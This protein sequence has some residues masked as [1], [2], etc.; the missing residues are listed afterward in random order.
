ML[1]ITWAPGTNP[2]MDQTFDRLREQQ[3]RD[4]KHRLWKNY[5]IKNFDFAVA[6]TIHFGDDGQP[7]LCSSIASRA[8]WPSGAYRI[9]NRLWKVPGIRKTNAPSTMSAS[10]GYSALSQIDWLKSNSNCQLYFISR[11]TDNWESWVC[12][13]FRQGHGLDFTIGQ[14][15]Y[16]TCPNECDQSCWQRIIYNGNEEL[17]KLWKQRPL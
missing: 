7:E 10:F 3:Y 1:T 2:E 16:L 6:L 14:H 11:E 5:S 17:L 12:R 4:H 9:L 13:Q 8:C 15:K